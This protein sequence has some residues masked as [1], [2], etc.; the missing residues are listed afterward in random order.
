[1]TQIVP[2]AQQSI[3][4]RKFFDSRKSEI[5][6]ALARV[7]I[8]PDRIVR[9]VFTAAQKNPEILRCELE[10]LYKAV[11]LAAQAGLMP[12][13]VTQQAH[14]IPRMNR[15]RKD[16]AGKPLPE[17]LECNLQIGYRGYLTLCR[18]SGDVDVIKATLVRAGDRFKVERGTEDRIT[19]E[20]LEDVLGPDGK[21]RPITHVYAV[22]TFKSGHKDFEDMPISE[23]E[24]L[25][26]RANANGPAWETDY[27]EMVKKTVLRR[28]CKRLPQS[29]DAARLLELDAQAEGGIPQ[30]ISEIPVPGVD[31]PIQTEVTVTDS[32]PAKP[33]PKRGEPSEEEKAKIAA[34]EKASMSDWTRS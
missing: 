17:A 25:R 14:L 1:M 34:E 4:V 24:Q 16:P 22:A 15:K 32:A 7:G 30:S 21:P 12:D 13:G 5:G 11:L 6:M 3:A 33:A 29:E 10:T 28:L 8:T 19:H 26:I 27:G 9:A 23:V 2:I 31:E 18:R 20:P